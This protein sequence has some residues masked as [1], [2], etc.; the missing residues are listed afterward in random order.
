VIDQSQP[1]LET[2]PDGRG[3]VRESRDSNTNARQIACYVQVEGYPWAV[4]ILLP[5]EVVLSSAT[6]IA[7]PLIILLA[8]LA[9]IVGIIIP[10]A[11]R[12]LTRPLNLL[13]SAANRIAEVMEQR[14]VE[15]LTKDDKEAI[16][17]FF[18]DHSEK[19]VFAGIVACFGL[20]VY[21][22]VARET[23]EKQPQDLVTAAQSATQHVNDG[24]LDPTVYE[25][26]D[27]AQIAK[28]NSQP[29]GLQP[30]RWEKPPPA[31]IAANDRRV[32]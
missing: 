5:Y 32:G 23:F 27:Y 10:F 30:Y 18:I 22:A 21:R 1:P 17:A 4:A 31:R 28:A 14:G 19:I 24:V 26:R 20:I 9:A 6:G 7:A 13:S 2:L 15:A 11:A 12:Q 8:V 25:H 16:K 29:I 3:W